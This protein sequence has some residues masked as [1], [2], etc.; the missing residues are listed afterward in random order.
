MVRRATDARLGREVRRRLVFRLIVDCLH[1]FNEQRAPS[2]GHGTLQQMIREVE[3]EIRGHG[4]E[5]VQRFV[6]DVSAGKNA[7]S[8]E[9]LFRDGAEPFLRGVWPQER[10]LATPSVSKAFSDLP[11]TSRGEFASAV[12]AI[13]RFLVPFEC[14]SLMD[15]GLFGDD[16]DEPKLNIIDN[17]EKAAALLRLLDLTIGSSETARVPYDLARALERIRDV[18]HQLAETP[19][20][21]RLATAAR[22]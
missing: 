4:A 13:E 7:P 2:I 15:Y 18:A 19:T 9:K 22:M 8:P 5:T 1:A 6:K 11:T 20:F 21:R 3:D 17:A 14:W 16:D 10:S 12:S